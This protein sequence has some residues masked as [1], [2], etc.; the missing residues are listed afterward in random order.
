MGLSILCSRSLDRFFDLALI[1]KSSYNKLIYYRGDVVQ[2]LQKNDQIKGLVSAVGAYA[3]WGF[4]PIYWKLLHVPAYEILAHRIVWSFVLVGLIIFLTNRS[5]QV[6]GDWRELMADTKRRNS[7]IAASL[8]IS[9]NWLTYIWAVNE[10]RIVETSFGYYINPLVSVMLGI[11]FLKERLSFWQLFSCIIAAAGVLYMAINFGS[12]PWVSLVLAGTFGLYG[13]CKKIVNIGAITSIAI[14]T[15][16]VTPLALLYIGFLEQQGYG[17]FTADWATAALLAGA[18]V[19]TA[20]PMLLFSCGANRLSLTILGFAQYLSPTIALL[21][22]VFAYHEPF[23][24]V[25]LVS[26]SLIWLAL[27]IFSFSRTRPFMAVENLLKKTFK[28]EAAVVPKN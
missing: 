14:E 10:S 13:L 26:F 9:V 22:G 12:V 3:L 4:L 17:S 11:I 8:L 25:H 19:V 15:L 27:T 1:G 23:T 7:L 28:K 2:N 21:V 16:L 18:G 24:S 5:Q 6:L 20:I